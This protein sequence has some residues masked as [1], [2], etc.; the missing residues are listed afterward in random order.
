MLQ[1]VDPDGY[2]VHPIPN[3]AVFA[4]VAVSRS[5]LAATW[6]EDVL[7]AVRAVLE[8]QM[9]PSVIWCGSLAMR[10]EGEAVVDSFPP[11]PE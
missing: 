5:V 7:E 4:A 9:D 2:E 3:D 10:L 8:P 1:V 6:M 11:S